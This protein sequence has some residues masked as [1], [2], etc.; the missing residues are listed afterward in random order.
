MPTIRG[1]LAI[2]AAIV[3]KMTGLTKKRKNRIWTILPK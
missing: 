3:A 2:F 1:T